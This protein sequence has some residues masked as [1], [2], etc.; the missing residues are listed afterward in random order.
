MTL[1]ETLSLL[2]TLKT[3]TNHAPVQKEFTEKGLVFTLPINGHKVPLLITRDDI[4]KLL[5]L[6]DPN[7]KINLSHVQWVRNV[8]LV[9]EWVI[10]V[11]PTL[12]DKLNRPTRNGEEAVKNYDIW[13]KKYTQQFGEIK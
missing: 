5:K 12:R 1:V 2:D 13:L 10:Y 3:E 7:K 11:K 8:P 6:P 9:K 4:E